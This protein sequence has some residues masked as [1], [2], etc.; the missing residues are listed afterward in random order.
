MYL[1]YDLFNDILVSYLCFCFNCLKDY[2][3]CREFF[4]ILVNVRVNIFVEIIFNC[5]IYI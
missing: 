5:L 2:Y 3:G 4:E 1:L